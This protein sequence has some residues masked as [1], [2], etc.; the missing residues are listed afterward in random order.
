[1]KKQKKMRMSGNFLSHLWQHHHHQDPQE[2]E[3]VVTKPSHHHPQESHPVI[4][5]DERVWNWMSQLEGDLNA[6]VVDQFGII[7]KWKR[8]DTTSF[9]TPFHSTQGCRHVSEEY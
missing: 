7:D 4:Q 1:M 6:M 9:S 8:A 2:Q 5:H 3:E